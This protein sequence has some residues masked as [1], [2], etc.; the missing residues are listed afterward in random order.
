MA[1]L[2]P[3]FEDRL[4]NPTRDQLMEALAGTIEASPLRGLREGLMAAARPC[5]NF[6]SLAPDPCDRMGN[7]RFGGMPDLPEGLEYP[8]TAAGRCWTFLAQIDLAE[9]VSLN[10]ALPRSGLLLFFIENQ[11]GPEP[12]ARAI[13]H[14]G[15]V[16]S[17]RRSRPPDDAPFDDPYVPDGG[18][19]PYTA[20]ATRGLSLPDAFSGSID[21]LPPP[22]I[23]AFSAI[24]AD[25]GLGDEYARLQETV[26]PGSYVSA[27]GGRDAIHRIGGYVFTQLESP[28]QRA[29]AAAGGAP[30]DWRC[31]LCL[32]YDNNTGFCFW[33]AGDLYFMIRKDDLSERRFERIFCGLESA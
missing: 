27:A 17:L 10:D 16:A 20:K 25:D 21:I 32:G 31:L 15:D 13:L 4:Q 23:A 5:V 9:I 29:A 18:Y 6:R 11:D 2:P 12:K 8:R 19:R 28:E 24:R 3:I 14:E 26:C 7:T 30:R 1:D 22:A 33:D